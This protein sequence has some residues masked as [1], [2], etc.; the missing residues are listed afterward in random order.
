MPTMFTSIRKISFLST[1]STAAFLVVFLTSAILAKKPDAPRRDRECCDLSGVAGVVWAGSDPVMT[2]QELASYCGPILW[3]SPDEPLLGRERGKG[4]RLTQHMF[5]EED[6]DAPVMYYRVDDV[7]SRLDAGGSAL[8]K[9]D[10]NKEDIMIDLSKVNAVDLRYCLYYPSE[11]G[12]GSHQHDLEVVDM[13]VVVYTWDDWQDKPCENCQYVVAITRVI[14]RAHGLEWYD[15]HLVVDEGAE[16]PMGILVEEGKHANCPDKNLDGLY[17]PGFDVNQRTNDA[18]GIRDIMRGGKVFTG[19]FESWMNK[20]RKEEDRVF[21]PLPE[22]SWVI[23]NHKDD[24]GV[25]AAENAIYVLRPL[26]PEELAADDHTLTKYIESKGE[27]EWPI[28][29]ADTEIEKLGGWFKQESFSKSLSIA[30][31]YDGNSG[32]SFS[33]PFFVIKHLE[34]PMAGGWIVHRMYLKDHDLRDFGWML[35]YAPSASRWVD[36]YLAAGVEWDVEDIPDDFGGTREKTQD[37]F[38]LES[39]MKLRVNMKY[40]PAKFLAKITPFWGFRVGL[41]YTGN[42][43]DFRNLG[44][45]VEVGAGTF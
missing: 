39:G 34:D 19:G 44:M 24:S 23:D 35:M 29:H 1:L 22:D 3:F 15:N 5:F 31:R 7:A 8:S 43:W 37:L 30:Y 36:G 41:K 28:E 10:G 16:F 9:L 2:L 21:P 45:I 13:K 25:Y 11:V 17:T 33:F 14:G 4:I 38:V 40:S 20:I 12:L 32:V 26:P 18:W 6:P 27:Y 42:A